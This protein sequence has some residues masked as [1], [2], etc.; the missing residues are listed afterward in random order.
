M[1]DAQLDQYLERE[2]LAHAIEKSD[3]LDKKQIEVELNE[4]KKEMLIGR[5]FENYLKTAVDENAIKNYYA[6]NADQFQTKKVKVAHCINS[7]S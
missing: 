3:F 1:V 7:Y 4:F 5:Y 6:N 2:S